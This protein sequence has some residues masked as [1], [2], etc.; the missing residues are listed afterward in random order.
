MLLMA[1]VAMLMIFAVACGSKSGNEPVQQPKAEDQTPVQEA[2]P[3]ERTITYLGETYTVP[4]KVERIV[5]TGAMEVLED[6]LVLDVHPVGAS[7]VGG[8]FPEIYAA[9]TDQATS[10]GEKREPNLEAILQLKPDVILGTTKFPA[11][12]VEK[13]EKIAP[14]ILVSHLAEEWQDGLKL[15]GELT[16]KEDQVQQHIDAYETDLE[17]SKEALVEK[18][19]DKKVLAVRLRRGE[20]NVY[21]ENIFVNPVLYNDLGLAVPEVVQA[22][23]QQQ[24]LSIEQFAEV[25][26]DYLFIQFAEED[27]ADAPNILQDLQN[28]PIVQNMK[29][30]KEG[31]AFVN[32]IDPLCEGG[33]SYSRIKFLE[34]ITENIQ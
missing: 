26:P 6:S 15:L 22:A 31:N 7:T 14:T 19:A 3:T 17:K 33:P 10:I 8:V 16:G 1:M 21:P 27:N 5:V 28:N 29:A 25:N 9:V 34:A 11:E 23:K 30:F 18:L 4:G 13:L 32:V 20:V 2:A 24:A 12:T